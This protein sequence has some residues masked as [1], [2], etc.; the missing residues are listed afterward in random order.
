MSKYL[1]FILVACYG[2][3]TAAAILL[4]LDLLRLRPHGLSDR[5]ICLIIAG[6]LLFSFSAAW[7]LT[8]ILL[9][10]RPVRKPILEEEQ[11]LLG[12]LRDIM[13][14][15]SGNSRNYR[16]LIHEDNAA[17]A[18]A[19]G[20][21]T[22]VVYRGLLM[23]LE[24]QEVRAVLAHELGHHSSGDPV[25]GMAFSIVSWLPRQIAGLIRIAW[26]FLF[27]FVRRV[28]STNLLLLLVLFIALLFLLA[29]SNLLYYV[30]SVLAFS[31][32]LFFL[33]R[34]FNLLWFLN[35]RRTEYR[36]DAFAHQLGFGYDLKIALQKLVGNQPQ[37]VS[38]FF[39]LQ[40]THPVI[41]NRIRKLEQLEGLR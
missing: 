32:L 14:K 8:G 15:Q 38:F 6:W 33:N 24:P 5:W 27:R 4:F 35:S 10:F 39:I 7:W 9:L 37:K 41:F 22:I 1:Q 26:G 16:L 18:Y 28:F 30:V 13:E 17:N 25:A 36:Q 20:C 29:Y 2:F 19:I 34:I 23:E 21:R 11:L 3:L 40:S 12:Q 31:I